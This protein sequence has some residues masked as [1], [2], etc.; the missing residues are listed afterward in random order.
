M[1][2]AR[3]KPSKPTPAKRRR[4]KT[5]EGASKVASRLDYVQLFRATPL[6]R[7]KLVKSR[8]PASQAKTIISDLAI[9]SG[10]ASRALHVS[11]S[12]LNRKTKLREALT[13]DESER[14]LGLAKLIGQVQ[15]MVDDSGDPSGFDARAWTARWLSEPLPALGGA[16]PLD[17]MDTM[18]GQSLVAETLARIQ[19]GAYA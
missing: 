11:V 5:P 10:S 6:D 13:Q 3:P 2:S 8:L 9:P 4:P 14:V 1:T 15:S 12:T 7:I 16:R 17:L 18:E 19:S